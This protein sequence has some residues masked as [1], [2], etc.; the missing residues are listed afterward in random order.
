MRLLR[1][2]VAGAI[3][4]GAVALL[5]GLEPSANATVLRHAPGA[6]ASSEREAVAPSS[7][8]TFTNS[9]ATAVAR[10]LAENYVD[11]SF[12][13]PADWTIDPKTGRP[14]AINFVKVIRPR[15][16]DS[17]DTETF[18][19]GYFKATGD[20]DFDAT[21]IP[22]LLNQFK[23]QFAAGFPNFVEIDRGPT[24][25]NGI[26]GSQLRFQS[27]VDGESGR[28]VI[29]GRVILIKPQ[30]ATTGV[31]LVLLGTDHAPELRGIDDLGVAGELPVILA[32]FRFSG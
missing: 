14:D 5:P 21:L 15:T 24:S 23:T 18:A 8:A 29:W 25:V 12:D 19:V 4:V 3:A 32:S 7:F 31:T 13:Y 6:I 11:F 26:A 30:K 16:G 28:V 20:P 22:Q 2:K 1:S 10:K 27:T 17:I 9:R